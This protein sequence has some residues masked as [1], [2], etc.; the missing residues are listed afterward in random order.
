MVTLKLDCLL[1]LTN[2]Q[3][4]IHIHYYNKKAIPIIVRVGRMKL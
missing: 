2:N 1:L 3:Y 4:L